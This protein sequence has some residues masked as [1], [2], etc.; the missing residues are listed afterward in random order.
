MTPQMKAAITRHFETISP[1]I[2]SGSAIVVAVIGYFLN[3]KLSSVN[4]LQEDVAEI[5]LSL[6]VVEGN[7]FTAKDGQKMWEAL[8]TK[9][10]K[11]DVPPPQVKQSL[12]RLEKLTSETN[13]QVMANSKAIERLTVMIEQRHK[14]N[15]GSGGL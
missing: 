1:F 13:D 6:A 2:L 4:Q 5:R 15:S 12:E 8:S 7:R 9:A 14:L 3:D 10:D 11:D